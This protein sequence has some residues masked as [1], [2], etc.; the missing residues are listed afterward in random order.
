MGKQSV[1]I[2]SSL[3]YQPQDIWNAVAAFVPVTDLMPVGDEISA[4]SVAILECAKTHAIA[5]QGSDAEN[6]PAIPHDFV[7]PDGFVLL[8]LTE[9]DGVAGLVLNKL[10]ITRERV[11]SHLVQGGSAE[12]HTPES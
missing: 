2:L 4:E 10:G 3:G 9:D 11:H 6:L 12:P 5:V 1:G 7:L 8:A